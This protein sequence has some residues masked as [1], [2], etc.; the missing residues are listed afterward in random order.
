MVDFQYKDRYSVEDFRRIITILRSEDGCPWDHDGAFVKWGTYQYRPTNEYF[1]ATRNPW[2]TMIMCNTWFVSTVK[3]DWAAL[4]EKTGGF[5]NA[6]ELIPQISSTY[7]IA[8]KSD[9]LL[10]NRKEDQSYHS[11]YTKEW[12]ELRIAWMNSVFGK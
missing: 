10:W 6:I 4:Y 1:A 3:N 11:G 7:L 9:A 8:F 5:K 12:L 2:Y